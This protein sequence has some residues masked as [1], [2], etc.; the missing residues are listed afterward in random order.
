MS[1]CGKQQ[2]IHKLVSPYPKQN[3]PG[4][5]KLNS[6]CAQIQIEIEITDLYLIRDCDSK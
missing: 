6:N 2:E 1:S 4:I 3:L 5:P